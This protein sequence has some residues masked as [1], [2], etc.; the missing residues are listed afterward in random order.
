M[1]AAL[2][3]KWREINKKWQMCVCVIVLERESA[4]VSRASLFR[5]KMAVSPE[6]CEL[7]RLETQPCVF[8]SLAL[9]LKAIKPS[10]TSQTFSFY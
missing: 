4:Q 9:L 6:A 1:A 3:V 5:S 2:V 10:R 7:E 8:P